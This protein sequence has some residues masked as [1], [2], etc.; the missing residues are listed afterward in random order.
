MKPAFILRHLDCEGAGYLATVLERHNLPYRVVAI[1]D[2]ESPPLDVQDFSALVLMGGPM[3]V[4]D[5]LPWIAQ[6]VELIRA[7]HARQIPVLGHC[8]GA[9]L[10]ATAFGQT[11]R[12]NHS[13]EIGWYDI[14]SIK[15]PSA[16]RWLS[17][18]PRHFLG[19]HWHGET[20]GLPQ[21]AIPLFRST[22]C[23]QQG[24]AIGNTLALQFHVEITEQMVDE[25]AARNS[26]EL[27][28]P[29]PGVQTTAQLR[30]NMT[31]RVAAL[32]EVADALYAAW[33]RPL[34]RNATD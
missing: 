3:S 24:F 5:P 22:L 30:E 8:L 2:G 31:G 18:V 9:Q 17:E 34:M 32:H 4:N 26:A 13:K 14:E 1:D 28:N 11:V 27:A 7:A 6:E 25:W 12:P 33:L 21:E 19:F 15:S 23:Q 10:I 29:P 20:F 16:A